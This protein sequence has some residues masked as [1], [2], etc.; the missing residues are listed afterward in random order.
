MVGLQVDW[1]NLLKQA[2]EARENAYAPY[3]GFRVGAAVAAHTGEIFT[4]CN[5]ESSSFGLTLCAERVALVGAVKAGFHHLAAIAIVAETDEPTPPCG[6]CRQVMAEFDLGV[7]VRSAVRNG[8]LREWT[9]AQLLP[10]PFLIAQAAR[11]ST[12]NTAN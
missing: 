7:V 2:W 12:W 5:V 1:N 4:G 9:L 11:G 3:S 8:A 10:S 6:A